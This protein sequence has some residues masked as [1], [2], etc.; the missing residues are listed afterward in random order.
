MTCFYLTRLYFLHKPPKRAEHPHALPSV[1]DSRS[2]IRDGSALLLIF[3]ETFA[4]VFD[5]CFGMRL[6]YCLVRDAF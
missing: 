3:N 5:R 1:P 2:Y 4:P 6:I